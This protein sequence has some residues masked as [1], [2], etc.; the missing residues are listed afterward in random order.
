MPTLWI[1]TPAKAQMTSKDQTWKTPQELAE[2]AQLLIAL[3]GQLPKAN[4]STVA[5][6]LATSTRHLQR[7]LLEAGTTFRAEQLKTRMR[8]A[9]RLLAEGEESL[10][11]IAGRCGY[12]HAPAFTRAFKHQHDGITP[13]E[14]RARGPGTARAAQRPQG[15][16]GVFLRRRF[17]A[18]VSPAR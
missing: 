14:W 3:I 7:A 5:A 2:H 6:A 1:A 4:E 13:R 15:E 16:L 10:A 18:I 11:S 17:H 9:E 12:A 8:R